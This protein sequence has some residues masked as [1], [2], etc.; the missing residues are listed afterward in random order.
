MWIAVSQTAKRCL[1]GRLALGD[2]RAA[3]CR[4]TRYRQ[5]QSGAAGI[6]EDPLARGLA[7]KRM[8]LAAVVERTRPRTSMTTMR[9]TPQSWARREEGSLAQGSAVPSV[10]R[11]ATGA[12]VVTQAIEKSGGAVRRQMR[13]KNGIPFLKKGYNTQTGKVVGP[14]DAL[15]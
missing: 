2:A 7:W 14:K 8:R 11:R 1:K 15:I 4:P 9:H 13:R 5:S 10:A 3:E 12:V 6:A